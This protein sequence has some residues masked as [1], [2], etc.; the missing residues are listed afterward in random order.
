MEKEQR[1]KLDQSS[2]VEVNKKEDKKPPDLFQKSDLT[3]ITLV[4]EG[5]ELHFAKYPL[6]AGSSVFTC[7]IRDSEN[8]SRLV[9]DDVPYQNMIMFLES[10][11]PKTL[12]VITDQTLEQVTSIAHRFKHE[13]ILH[14][15]E[16]YIVER[17]N[18]E[19][20]SMDEMYP[21]FF[22]HLK[23][24]DKYGLK[25]AVQAGVLSKRVEKAYFFSKNLSRF[26]LNNIIKGYENDKNFNLLSSDTKFEIL[27][28]R[29]KVTEDVIELS[30][31]F[32]KDYF[33]K[34]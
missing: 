7:M 33:N 9:L 31:P 25:K 2:V 22:F 15:C 6:I 26:G 27:R 11:H 14:K 23:V 21:Q 8:K 32:L 5:K 1:I 16:E 29:L 24:A 4:V 3:D 17:F 19:C 13:G 12:K 10:L 20:K 30:D 28:R 34:D 18:S